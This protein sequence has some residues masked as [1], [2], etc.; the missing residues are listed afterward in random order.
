M[1][2]RKDGSLVDVQLSASLL[3]DD[4][5]RLFG[6]IA[7]Y[8]DI[9]ERKAME[10]ELRR[11]A[12]TDPLT[13][14]ANRTL[15]AER[16]EAAAAAGN[17]TVLLLDLDG[18]KGVNDTLGHAVGDRVLV[19]VAERTT[20]ATRPGDLVARLGGDE[21]VV[22]LDPATPEDGAEQLAAR[23]VEVL[24]Q[25]FDLGA[26]TASLGASIG[27]AR[28]AEAGSADELLRDADVAMYAAK[29]RGKARYEVFEPRLRAALLERTELTSDLRQA[30]A[31]GELFLRYHPV[32]DVPTRRV[33]GFEALVR[34]QHPVRGELPPAAF[35]PLAEEAGLVE[36]LGE[37]V[38]RQAC[39]ALRTWQL[40]VTDGG[41]ARVGVNLSPLQLRPSIVETVRS[42]LA[43]SGLSPEAL[44]LELTED[45]VLEDVDAAVAVLRDLRALGVT[46]AIDD[47]GAGY[48]SLGYLK[49]LPVQIVKID[50]ALV[51]GVETDPSA[52]ALLDAVVSLIARLGMTAVAE[53][54]ETARAVAAA[55][56]A[57]LPDR[58]GLPLA[59]PLRARRRGRAARRRRA[60]QRRP[61]GLTGRVG[62]CRPACPAADRRRL[63]RLRHDAAR[64][65]PAGG[66]V[67]VGAR[68][69]GRRPAPGRPRCRLHR[70]R[71]AGREPQG[72]RVLPPGA[73]GADP[74]DRAA[75]G[76][77][78][79]PAPR[80]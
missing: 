17:A 7:V 49:Q 27:L 51:A 50:R 64:R 10:R 56:A 37:Q 63:P 13:G 12:Y 11:A 43:E 3:H 78:V 21:F 48:S 16:L 6:A 31:D 2:P 29:A 44:V 26:R 57:R 5:G 68:Q 9:T 73:H 1:R 67:A 23:L 77:R 72:R 32:V 33:L 20:A 58:P 79:D 39:A 35:L 19:E 25:P 62:G 8:V 47:F 53:G 4:E 75:R 60:E 30:L 71:L 61:A 38:L 40:E 42:V 18:F 66:H 28:L 15:F 76:V 69:A 70:G 24:G 46:L 34:W 59:Q 41:H 55:G 45:V 52:R 74:A 14:L 22:L 65:H 54:V 36:V 80:R